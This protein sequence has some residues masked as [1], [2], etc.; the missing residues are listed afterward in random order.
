MDR[1]AP[2]APT[3][4]TASGEVMPG[5]LIL[6][7]T[8]ACNLRCAYCPTAKDGWPSLTPDDARRAVRLF[9]DRYGGGDIKLFGGEPLLV[10]DVADAAL[11]EAERHDC[12]RRI[13]ISTNGLPLDRDWLARFAKRRK[14]MLTVSVDGRPHDHARLRRPVDAGAPDSHAHILSLLDDLLRV[15]RV[16]VTQTIAPAT[17]ADAFHNFRYLLSLGFRRVNILPGYYLAWRDDQLDALRRGFERIRKEV[18]RWWAEGR[19]LSLVNLTVLA[20]TPFFNTGVVVDSDRTIHVS[21]VGL[22]ANLDHLRAQTVA[23]DLDDPPA[24]AALAEGARR[25]NALLAD[26]L[27]PR[28]WASTLAVDAELTRLCE[29]LYAPLATR[30]LLERGA[31]A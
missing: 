7:L 30:L 20:P 16:V 1:T 10:P 17:A 12:I 15:P 4:L 11:D 3:A 21:N 19:E 2:T 31:V 9:A 18:T 23:G 8:R 14:A 25:V 28:V 6:T 27:P 29:S 24:P 13:S 5:S 22:A 26:A